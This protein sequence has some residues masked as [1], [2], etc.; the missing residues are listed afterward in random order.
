MRLGPGAFKQVIQCQFNLSFVP[1]LARQH[2]KKRIICQCG[3]ESLAPHNPIWLD[4]V[5]V[6]DNS[7]VMLNMHV[8]VQL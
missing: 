3:N 2:G 6:S 8:Q 5:A 1:T 7:D 4:I